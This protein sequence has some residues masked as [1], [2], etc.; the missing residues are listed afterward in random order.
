MQ[1]T[2]INSE[3]IRDGLPVNKRLTHHQN[4]EF[5]IAGTRPFDH[6]LGVIEKPIDC[7]RLYFMTL[8][9]NSTKNLRKKRLAFL[10]ERLVQC[11]TLHCT[12]QLYPVV[13]EKEQYLFPPT[14]P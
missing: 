7:L 13:L 4:E 9:D 12:I 5:K 1:S 11:L 10:L 3:S 6:F 14:N 8:S 2:S